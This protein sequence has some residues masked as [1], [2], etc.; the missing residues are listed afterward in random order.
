MNSI[1]KKSFEK[2]SKKVFCKGAKWPIPIWNAIGMNFFGILFSHHLMYL[3]TLFQMFS[4]VIPE[5]F[6]TDF[7]GIK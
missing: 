1:A 2:C 7:C 6:S 5:P 4:K 3:I